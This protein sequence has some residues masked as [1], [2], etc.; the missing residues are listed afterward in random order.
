MVS[1]VAAERQIVAGAA[2]SPAD[3]LVEEHRIGSDIGCNTAAGCTGRM[4]AGS[5]PAADTEDTAG[6]R[7]RRTAGQ[8]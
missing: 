8:A 6:S 3:S 1:I 4:A 5:S 2:G 7:S